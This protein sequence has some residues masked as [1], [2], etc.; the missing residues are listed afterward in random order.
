M[1][2][3]TGRVTFESAFPEFR[4]FSVQSLQIKRCVDFI[5]LTI[6]MEFIR[7]FGRDLAGLLLQELGIFGD[8][9][10]KCSEYLC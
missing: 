6:D 2:E 9:D 4:F 1:F 5:P 8:A 7:G 3:P 10:R